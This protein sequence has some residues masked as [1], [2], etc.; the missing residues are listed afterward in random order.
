MNQI[1][2][3]PR[4]NTQIYLPLSTLNLR[5]VQFNTWTFESLL[6]I[7]TESRQQ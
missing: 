4:C 7:A 6:S 5:D 3:N 1:Y 2:D